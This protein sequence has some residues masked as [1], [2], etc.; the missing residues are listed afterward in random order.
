MDRAPHPAWL[1]DVDWNY[2]ALAAACKLRTLCTWGSC[3]RQSHPPNQN[4]SQSLRQDYCT[5]GRGALLARPH[6]FCKCTRCTGIGVGARSGGITWPPPASTP[7]EDAGQAPQA[8]GANVV[9]VSC[10]SGLG[11]AWIRDT[12]PCEIA[13]CDA[14]VASRVRILTSPWV[15][16]SPN[17][18]CG[19]ALEGGNAPLSD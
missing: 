15:L 18:R 3:R 6:P 10:G 8:N 17:S 1:S 19:L 16:C 7:G 2:K 14:C 12:A 5:M 13:W 11:P 4:M 9:S